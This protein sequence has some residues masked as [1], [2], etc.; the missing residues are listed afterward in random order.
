MVGPLHIKTGTVAGVH[1]ALEF[2]AVRIVSGQ[3]AAQDPDGLIRAVAW[4]DAASLTQLPFT[5]PEDGQWLSAHLAN[6]EGCGKLV[7]DGIPSCIAASGAFARYQEAPRSAWPSLLLAKLREEA[8]EV[9]ASD[10][11]VQ[12]L[13]DLLEVVDTLAALAGLSRADLQAAQDAKRLSR[14]GFTRGI[15]LLAAP[16]AASTAATD[17][18]ILAHVRH[19]LQDLGQRLAHTVGRLSPADL[20][21]RPNAESN[22]AG[23]LVTHICGNLRQR[24]LSGIGGAPDERDRDAEFADGQ[25]SAQEGVALIK[26]T[27]GAVD[28]VLATLSARQLGRQQEIRGVPVTALEV[29]V[30][31]V[32]HTAEHVGQVLYIAKARLGPDFGTLSLPRRHPAG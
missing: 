20:A 22:G 11:S 7:R 18:A 29:L 31:A 30:R 2:F 25:W 26:E 27:F 16:A 32:G 13:A 4:H 24:I 19:R 12:E 1:Y 17:D 14:G 21:W 23:A 3:A 10:G 15:V 5:F 9:A 8:A 6:R 28:T